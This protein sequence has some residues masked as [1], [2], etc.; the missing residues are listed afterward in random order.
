[1]GGDEEDTEQNSKGQGKGS[2]KED[3]S[4]EDFEEYFAECLKEGDALPSGAAPKRR[5][6]GNQ[7][8]QQGTKSGQ[9]SGKTQ[10]GGESQGK[11]QTGRVQQGGE[12]ERQNQGRG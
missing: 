10:R 6:R 1:M 11:G 3:F 12:T 7:G 2:D 9:S 4:L 8:K 5:M